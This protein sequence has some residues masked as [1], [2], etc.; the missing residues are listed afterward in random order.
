M[1]G[2]SRVRARSAGAAGTCER[3]RT[4]AL[5]RQRRPLAVRRVP[6]RAPRRDRDVVV[7]DAHRHRGCVAAR[8]R[9][10]ARARLPGV[11]TG[12]RLARPRL[13]RAPS[14]PSTP[15]PRV[16]LAPVGRLPARHRA[17]SLR[18]P[19][20]ARTRACVGTR[21]HACTRIR[22]RTGAHARSLTYPFA[23]WLR[24]SGDRGLLR[25]VRPVQ[26]RGERSQEDL[27]RPL[28]VKG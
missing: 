2:A 11:P 19:L 23:A 16:V 6:R 5:P 25:V 27:L 21:A 12:T 24:N 20:V 28:R 4:E 3:G 9:L 13:A 15:P 26:G 7:P 17:P 10:R 8:G 1:L 18:M 22:T 14:S